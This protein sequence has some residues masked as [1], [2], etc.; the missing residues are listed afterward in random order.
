MVSESLF[1]CGRMIIPPCENTRSTGADE[2]GTVCTFIASWNRIG[3]SCLVKVSQ[4]EITAL[5]KLWRPMRRQCQSV[6]PHF[7]RDWS[8]FVEFWKLQVTQSQVTSPS[9]W[10][11]SPSPSPSPWSSSPSPSPSHQKLYSSRTRVQVLDSSTTTLMIDLPPDQATNVRCR[12]SPFHTPYW[13][14]ISLQS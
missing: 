8:S 10:A 6:K 1:L 9:P 4:Q 14:A 7:W 3:R 11:S 13:E 2:A 5:W 12:A